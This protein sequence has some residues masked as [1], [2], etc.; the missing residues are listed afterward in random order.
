MSF[1]TRTAKGGGAKQFETDDSDEDIEVPLKIV[2][3]PRKHFES[4]FV[5]SSGPGGQNVNKVNTKVILRVQLASSHWLPE[6][7]K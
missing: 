4:Q 6:I 1:A 7:V 5:K 2:L 3:D